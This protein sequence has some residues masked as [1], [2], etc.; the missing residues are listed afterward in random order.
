LGVGF[1]GVV[2]RRYRRRMDPVKAESTFP[3]SLDD[4]P[5]CIPIAWPPHP[6]VL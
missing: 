5:P 3:K 6:K 4:L 2:I 1:I